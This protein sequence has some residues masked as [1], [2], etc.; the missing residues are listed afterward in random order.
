[1]KLTQKKATG[2]E[3]EWALY[4]AIQRGVRSMRQQIAS[5]EACH[6]KTDLQRQATL[7]KKAAMTILH[8]RFA[9][10]KI[11]SRR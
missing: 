2:P 4:N 9:G 11:K 8:K 7:A 1:M 10:F 6:I 3:F 5:G